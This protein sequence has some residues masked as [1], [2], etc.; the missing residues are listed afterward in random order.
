MGKLSPGW[1]LKGKVGREDICIRHCDL[2]ESIFITHSK[3]P[4]FHPLA[5]HGGVNTHTLTYACIHIGE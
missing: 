5:S 1:D 2:A 4:L 3:S